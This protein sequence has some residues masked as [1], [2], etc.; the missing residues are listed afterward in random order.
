LSVDISVVI[1]AHDPAR[2]NQLHAALAS[3]NRQRHRPAETVLVIDHDRL[4]FERA[5]AQWPGVTVVENVGCRGLGGARNSGICA[6]SGSVVAF[7]DDDAIASPEWLSVFVEHYSDPDVAGVGGSIEPVW[8][9]A[10]PAWFPS[11]FDWVVGC[12]YRGL[13]TRR[14]QVRNVIG[15]SMAFRRDALMAVGGFRSELGRVGS[16]PAGCEETELCIRVG[17]LSRTSCIVFDPD[18]RADHAVPASRATLR[19]FVSRCWSE[20]RSKAI[21]AGLAGPRSGLSTERR[22]VTRVLPAAVAGGVRE[23]L[24][25]RSP[26]GWARAGAIALGLAVTVAGYVRGRIAPGAPAPR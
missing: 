2:W 7:L 14:A 16:R 13:P 21:V 25:R 12:T 5:R 23:G 18:I 10:R 3:L 4:L 15:A 11:E 24:L 6:S 22:Y 26:A 8:E 19:Y 20:G 1:C 9:H 17:R